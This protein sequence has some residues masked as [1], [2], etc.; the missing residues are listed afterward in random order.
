MFKQK[1]KQ[2]PS[3][4]ASLSQLYGSVLNEHR[5]ERLEWGV[6][7]T[8]MPLFRSFAGFACLPFRTSLDTPFPPLFEGVFGDLP[9][10]LDKELPDG[11]A[12]IRTVN[13]EVLATANFS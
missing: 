6:S 3:P 7:W 12:E 11:A 9:V 13:G 4:E 8:V 2:A 10:Y 5:Y 1:V